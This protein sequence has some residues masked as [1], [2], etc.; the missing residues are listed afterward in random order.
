MQ[1][2]DN[3]HTTSERQRQSLNPGCPDPEPERLNLIVLLLHCLSE[4]I[5]IGYNH[6]V[7]FIKQRTLYIMLNPRDNSVRPKTVLIRILQM[8]K[9]AH[10]VYRY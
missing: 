7:L 5:L 9:Q 8:R 2:L 10:R 6:E 3:S 4:I 1:S